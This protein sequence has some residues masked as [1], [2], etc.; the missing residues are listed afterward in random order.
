MYVDQALLDLYG[1]EF[2]ELAEANSLLRPYMLAYCNGKKHLVEKFAQELIYYGFIGLHAH[3]TY[4]SLVT[5]IQGSPNQVNNAK[6]D[7]WITK[8]YKF[9]KIAEAFKLA[10]SSN[11]ALGLEL[12]L[13]ED[14]MKKV[15]ETDEAGIMDWLKNRITNPNDWPFQ[16]FL[17]NSDGTVTNTLFLRYQKFSKFTPSLV[18]KKPIRFLREEPWSYHWWTT[19]SKQNYILATESKTSYL[20]TYGKPLNCEEYPDKYKPTDNVIFV[21]YCPSPANCHNVKKHVT[22]AWEKMAV[23]F[24]KGKVHAEGSYKKFGSTGKCFSLPERM[25]SS[26]DRISR[27][28][29]ITPHNH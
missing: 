10:S 13:E 16:C 28:G 5:A 1:V 18:S 7:V 21:N 19:A 24:I 20:V 22:V 15:S 8:L 4:R 29:Q 27:K 25:L 12:D 14:F 23:V 11:K 2:G 3:F 26:A 9:W 17:K 6:D